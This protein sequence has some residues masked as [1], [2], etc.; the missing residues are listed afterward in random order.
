[1]TL[2]NMNVIESEMFAYVNVSLNRPASEDI[3]FTLTPT[4]GTAKRK[5]TSTTNNYCL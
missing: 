1:M 5:Y 3:T 2:V 4:A